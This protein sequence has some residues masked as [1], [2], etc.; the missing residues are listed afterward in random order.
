MKLLVLDVEGTVFKTK[1]RLPGTSIDS[2]IWQA[3]ASALGPKAVDEEVQTHQHW[4]TGKYRSYLDW[5]KDTI[6]I[7][8]K[9]ELSENQFS[10]IIAAAE[11]NPGVVETLRRI[12][13]AHY[14][15]V[16][17]SGGFREL[18][19]RAQADCGISHAFS[20][21]E[22]LF[23]AKGALANWNLLPCDFE[24]KIDFIHLMLREYGLSSQD[25]LFVGDGKNDVPIAKAAPLS[26]AY[27]GNEELKKV[28][29]KHI[30]KFEELMP[31]LGDF[32]KAPEV[33]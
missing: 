4:E 11:Y 1:I 16:L 6:R 33:T 17:I 25:W 32:A 10:K 19:K 12:D 23:D 5:M 28:A 2:A 3:I 18:A 29:S 27:N 13:R 8:Q 9:H 26:V 30:G 22:Y 24:G 7:H 14:E 20:A 21:C 31:I 15:I